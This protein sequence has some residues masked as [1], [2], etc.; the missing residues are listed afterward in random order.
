MVFVLDVLILSVYFMKFRENYNIDNIYIYH[1]E[2]FQTR[3]SV[4]DMYDL[5]ICLIFDK[6]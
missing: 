3:G 5:S 1:G 2:Y 4:K 6:L